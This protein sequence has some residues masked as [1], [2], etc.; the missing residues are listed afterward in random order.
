VSAT[1][2]T[3]TL[4]ALHTVSGRGRKGDQ[5][6]LASPGRTVRWTQTG[7]AGNPINN[8]EHRDLSKHIRKV[9]TH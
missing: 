8:Q 1:E 7:K 2:D 5:E 4:K 3:G 6:N 9:R